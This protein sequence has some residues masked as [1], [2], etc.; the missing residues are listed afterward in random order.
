MKE[1]AKKYPRYFHNLLE[2]LLFKGTKKRPTHLE[3]AEPLDAVG[4]NYNAFTGEDYTGYY[5]KVDSKH[6]D[7]ALDVI[8]DIYLN[9]RLDLKEIKK[10]NILEKLDKKCPECGGI[11]LNCRMVEFTSG[12]GKKEEGPIS[13]TKLIFAAYWL[14]A[15]SRE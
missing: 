5:A 14:T 11:N 9:S 13:A 10:E 7:L 8:S 12:L 15:D 2:H 1:E 3:I 6:F 4:G